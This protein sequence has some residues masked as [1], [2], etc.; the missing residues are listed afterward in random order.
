MSCW[1]PRLIS[2]RQ[3]AQDIFTCSDKDS[4]S[5]KL[6]VSLACAPFHD[7]KD[8]G[9]AIES[10][11][12]EFV[13]PSSNC[14]DGERAAAFPSCGLTGILYDALLG[15]DLVWVTQGLRSG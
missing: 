15:S 11:V 7:C 1:P 9:S 4:A 5:P 12:E 8:A 2:T 6:D 3:Q 14:F 10:G 13:A